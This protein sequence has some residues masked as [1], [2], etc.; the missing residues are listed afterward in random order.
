MRSSRAIILLL[1]ALVVA[2]PLRAHREVGLLPLPRQI[3]HS[4]GYY[5]HHPASTLYTPDSE[6]AAYLSDYFEVSSAIDGTTALMVGINPTLCLPAEGYVI[7]VRAEGIFV[8]GVD[9]GG[10]FN[11]IQTLL[12]LFPPEIYAGNYRSECQ[13]ECMRIVDWPE[14][15]YRGM[16]VDVARTFIPIEE[17]LRYVDNLSRHKINTL[18]LHLVD[19]EGWRI[20]I[21]SH[22]ELTEVGAWRGGDSPLHSVYGKWGER[23]GGYYTQ[24]QL[25]SLVEYAA[26]RNITIVPEIDLPGHS[27][28]IA[29]SHPEILCPITKDLSRTAGY[30]TSNVWCV[31]REENYTLLD[32]IL[33]EVCDIFPS[34]YIHIGGDEVQMDSWRKCPHC[35]ALYAEQGMTDYHQLEGLFLNRVAEIIARYG[36]KPAFWNEAINGGNIPTH[37]R[38]HGWEAGKKAALSAQRGYQTVVMSGPYFY[39]DMRQSADEP[40]HNW[41]GVV[42][43]QKCYSYRLGEQGFSAEARGNVVGF[44]G[45]FWTELLVVHSESNPHYIDYQLYPRVCALAEIC[46]MPE[47]SRVWSDFE[48]RLGEFH[49]PRLKSLG[50]HYRQGEPTP[51]K[52]RLITP[53]MVCTSS[54]DMRNEGDLDKIST[55]S[56]SYGARAK[57]TCHDGDWI[58]YDFATSVTAGAT[59]E[60]TT[61]YR[62]VTRGLFPSGYVE[63]S[64]DGTH[65]ERTCELHN[66]R[67]TLLHNKPI[68]A[69][70]IVCTTTGNNDPYVFIQQPIIR[71]Q[72]GHS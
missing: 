55:Y 26:R 37:T 8:S 72:Q 63:I 58:R 27:L 39:F 31:A 38:I 49:L 71:V 12:Q 2:A 51:P 23:Y 44:S 48:H 32:D 20:E 34:E 16:H 15:S 17:L 54:I 61:G 28:A 46:W 59:I 68:K 42:T 7:D 14:Y 40:G 35:S 25:R 53:K 50:I 41:A 3:E 64:T 66:G 1:V 30:D 21:L 11:G 60:L 57:R 69:I 4:E 56:N 9:Y 19:D 65:F 33:R 13:I 70:R 5:L 62:H 45:A 18:H 67:A 24:Q 52:G 29:K 10:V 47:E 22:P 36:R 43:T 6:L